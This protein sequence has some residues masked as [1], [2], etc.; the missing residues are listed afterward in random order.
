MANRYWRLREEQNRKQNIQ[1]E[2][3]YDR[4]INS[5]YEQAF[6]EIQDEINSF[7]GKYARKEGISMAEAKKRVSR[8]RQS[9]QVLWQGSDQGD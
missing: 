8:R 2:K 4:E 6:D 1:D 7:Y 5:I 3:A 9:G